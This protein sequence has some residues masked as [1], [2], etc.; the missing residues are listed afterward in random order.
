MNYS[1]EHSY[2]EVDVPDCDGCAG[3][4]KHTVPFSEVTVD[5]VGHELHFGGDALADID[6]DAEETRDLTGEYEKAWGVVLVEPCCGGELHLMM[7]DRHL[8]VLVAGMMR[9]L[10]NR[11]PQL[12][13]EAIEKAEEL[14]I[15]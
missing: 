8:A 10:A 4:G 15:G 7:E 6:P 12:L 3:E 11:D 5:F 2:R 13:S 14:G 9:I 1:V